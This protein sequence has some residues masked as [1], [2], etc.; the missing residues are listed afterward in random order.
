MLYLLTIVLF[1]CLITSIGAEKYQNTE[2]E[3]FDYIVVGGGTAGGVV[4]V[5]LA[6]A[7]YT[8]LLM[9]AG[10]LHYSNYSRTPG[11]NK[12]A[13][14]DPAI[15]FE[16]F[17]ERYA[18]NTTQYQGD[19]YYPRTGTLGGCSTHNSMTYIYPNQRDFDLLVR[20]T[21]DPTFSEPQMRKYFKLIEKNLYPSQAAPGAHGEN[22][23]L[24]ISYLDILRAADVKDM[25]QLRDAHPHLFKV[26]S[27]FPGDPLHDINGYVKGKLGADLESHFRIPMNIDKD[28]FERGNYVK[29]ILDA[30]K[31]HPN[32]HIWTNTL[33]TRIILDEA[34]V[35]RGVAYRKG[36]YLY[37]ASPLSSDQ[38]RAKAIAGVAKARRE[39]IVS[40]GVFN[41]PQLLMLSGIGD[42]P[43]LQSH[44]IAPIVHL[45]GVGKS[46]GEHYLLSYIIQTVGDSAATQGPSNDTRSCQYEA[47]MDDYCYRQFAER[48]VGPYII[49]GS[50]TGWLRKSRPELREPDTCTL[51]S[52][53]YF[54]G[55]YKTQPVGPPNSASRI[56]FMGHP[57]SRGSV[58]L[59]SSDPFD[60]PSINFNF[61]PQDDREDMRVMMDQIRALRKD[62]AMRLK[63]DFKEILP[64]PEVTTDEQLEEFI[65]KYTWFGHHGCCTAKIG[66]DK[67]PLAVLDGKFRVRGAKHLRVVDASVYPEVPG[68]FT[69][70]FTHIIAMKA[71]DVILTDAKEVKL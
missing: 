42:R 40:S 19:G 67:D 43:H 36:A 8:T 39:V 63:G 18:P 68:F 15:A 4:A 71:A 41:T 64:G 23:W 33:G 24:P 9:E 7:G 53:G 50:L 62:T 58:Q 28:T 1:A 12:R 45:P 16:Y 22:G 56:I 2:N 51:T 46:L 54:R 47:S 55:V 14:H 32:L 30:A 37:R 13:V 3:V 27:A 69:A 17:P 61:F 21:Q 49:G 25:D 65:L 70:L 52:G 11:L 31:S 57:R 44:N 26:F 60:T 5:E 29:Y 59:K 35:A 6:K 34:K 10:P 66:S 20:V 38:N 48:H